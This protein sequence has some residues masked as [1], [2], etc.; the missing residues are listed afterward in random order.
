MKKSVYKRWILLFVLCLFVPLGAVA[1]TNWLVDPLW[2]FKYS[3]SFAPWH[4][5]FNDRQQKT[6]Y[7]L[8]TRPAV[9]TL[10]LG[11]SRKM[12]ADPSAW[13]DNGFNYA[14]SGLAP[15]E[16]SVLMSNIRELELPVEK[17]VL[18]LDF[19]AANGLK[20]KQSDEGIV[21]TKSSL[22]IARKI[23]Y[24]FFSLLDWKTFLYSIKAIRRGAS[25]SEEEYKNMMKYDHLGLDTQLFFVVSGDAAERKNLISGTIA[26]YHK[27]YQEFHYNESFSTRLSSFLQIAGDAEVIPLLTPVGTPFLRLIAQTPGRL[28][29]YERWIRESVSIFGGVWGF[30]D[31]NVVT[32]DPSLW[33]EPSHHSPEVSSWMADR[34][35]GRGEPPECF[36]VYIDKENVE[37]YIAQVREDIEKLLIEK[38]AWDLLME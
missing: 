12:Y 10:V 28:D 26:S 34:I 18:G 9:R 31:V 32:R 20:E 35:H 23:G 17:I 13:G 33:M 3:V 16:Y 36:G 25:A 24:R 4:E 38:D 19:F 21:T 6:N 22:E 15:L 29:D 1:F 8:F 7:L 14:V 37:T 11:S 5:L 27:T 2:S 30:M